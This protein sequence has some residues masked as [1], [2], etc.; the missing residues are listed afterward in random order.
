MKYLIQLKIISL[1]YRINNNLSNTNNYKNRNHYYTPYRFSLLE[2]KVFI[3][4]DRKLDII[5]R[6]GYKI[7]VDE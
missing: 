6:D 3:K 2:S 7:I 4:L 1:F 5:A